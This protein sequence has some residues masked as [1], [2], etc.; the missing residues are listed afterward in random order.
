MMP[1][2]FEDLHVGQTW[3]TPSRTVTEFDVMT[4]ASLTSDMHP[5][6]TDVEYCK[7]TRFEQRIA[8]GF[9]VASLAAGLG[10]RLRLTEGTIVANLGTSWRFHNPVKIGDTIHVVIRVS[11]LRPSTSRPEQG[12]V[13]REYEVR[14]QR[15][16]TCALGEVKVMF[17]R[18]PKAAA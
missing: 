18:R 5:L 10:F 8:H 15:A 9:L 7:T 13:T 4:F 17:L 16:E 1:L 12:V 11:E 3:T 14:N 6:H 2:Y